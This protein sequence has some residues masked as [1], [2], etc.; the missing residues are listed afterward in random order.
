MLSYSDLKKGVLFLKDGEPWEVL[1]S[2]FLRMQQR[3][4]VMQARIRNLIS[5]KTTDTSFAQSDSF[6]EAVID[7]RSVKF[8]FEHRGQY[9]FTEAKNPKD[10]FI[11]DNTIIGEKAK[12]LKPNTEIIAF[13]FNDK[14]ISFLLPVKMDLK[15]TEAPP[16]I[17]GDRAQGGNKA[18]VVETGAT[19]NT[20]LFINTGDII[21]VNTETGEYTERVEKA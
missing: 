1:E 20:P 11:L 2:N 21:R 17:I 5:G 8:L 12:W 9:T 13:F 4:P 15:V 3:R 16:G 7:R 6:E 19:V 10:R 18:V 14:I